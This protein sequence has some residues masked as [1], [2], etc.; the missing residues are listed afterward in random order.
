MDISNKYDVVIIGGGPAG[1]STALM[2]KRLTNLSILVIEAGHYA[3][4]RAG[5][6][7]PP[8][9]RL[10]FQQ[11]N[12]WQEFLNDNHDPCLGNRSAWGNAELGYNDYLF[13]PMGHGWH[14][15]RQKFDKFLSDQ[16]NSCGIDFLQDTKV[17]KSC[18]T[19]KNNTLSIKV[20]N[21][22]T[23]HIECRFVVDASGFNSSFAKR[24][25]ANKIIDDELVCITSFY[26]QEK[27]NKLKQLTLL[28]ATEYGWWYTAQLPDNRCAIA[29]TCDKSF[30]QYFK[31]NKHNNWLKLLKHSTKNVC[32]SLIKSE[33]IENSMRINLAS[34]YVLDKIVGQNWLTTGDAACAFDPISAGGIYKALTHGI[35]AAKTISQYF[36]GESLALENYA[37]MIES[38]FQHYLSNKIFLYQ[39]ERRWQKSPFWIRRHAYKKSDGLAHL[40]T[41]DFTL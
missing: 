19:N 39:Q 24:H 21:G 7:I 26:Q 2:L 27:N 35:S 15:N 6:S 30:S 22:F 41:A 16:V 18:F 14:L 10:L 37:N 29:L 4:Q 34:S 28:E 9:T 23:F 17:F 33:Y 32:Q 8:D 13:N 5:E 36:K 25:K 31:I 1:C 12:I 11:L 40:Q 38:D 20:K 3:K